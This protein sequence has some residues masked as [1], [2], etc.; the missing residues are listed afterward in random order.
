MPKKKFIAAQNL[1]IVY[2]VYNSKEEKQK[3]QKAKKKISVYF[4]RY[5][6]VRPS[7]TSA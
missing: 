4:L 1:E 7:A 6:C 2:Q 3:S 5:W